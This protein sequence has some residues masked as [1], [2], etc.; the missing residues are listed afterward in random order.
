METAA[1]GT[2]TRNNF[3]VRP[4]DTWITWL[5]SRL[6]KTGGTANQVPIK[7]NGTDYN[8]S[9]GSITSSIISDFTAAVTSVVGGLSIASGSNVG[10]GS[11]VYK[12]TASNVLSF[13]TLL[14]TNKYGSNALPFDVIDL[15]E[16]ANDITANLNWAALATLQDEQFITMSA[17]GDTDDFPVLVDNYPD[18]AAVETMQN[19]TTDALKV[20]NGATFKIEPKPYTAVIPD[21][22]SVRYKVEFSATVT[23]PS[24]GTDY[25]NLIV[26]IA[27][28]NFVNGDPYVTGAIELTNTGATPPVNTSTM[29]VAGTLNLDGTGSRYITIYVGKQEAPNFK[30]YNAFLTIRAISLNSTSLGTV[31][32][33]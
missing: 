10:G 6:F 17:S 20:P 14:A 15:T 2:A 22:T 1:D 5:V 12:S 29:Y 28:S 8:W 30:L 11:E 4:S 25:G 31:K 33:L 13:R 3:A 26:A 24:A 9:W 32:I 7:T 27:E 18:G 21:V 23:N 19:V 16:N